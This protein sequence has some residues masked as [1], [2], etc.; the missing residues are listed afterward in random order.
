[1]NIFMD[2]TTICLLVVSWIKYTW[3]GATGSCR[4][5]WYGDLPIMLSHKHWLGW[6]RCRWTKSTWTTKLRTSYSPSIPSIRCMQAIPQHNIES[7]S[8][9]NSWSC[10]DAR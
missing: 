3:P 8:T 1:V 4:H 9:L 6:V 10:S 2:A 5:I 7:A